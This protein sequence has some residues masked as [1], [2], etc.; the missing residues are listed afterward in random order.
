MT[1]PSLTVPPISTDDI[2]FSNEDNSNLSCTCDRQI[3]RMYISWTM[4]IEA[5][6]YRS[7]FA[8]DRISEYTGVSHLG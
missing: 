1:F 2:I 5:I 8:N 6:S 7:S 3:R 4:R